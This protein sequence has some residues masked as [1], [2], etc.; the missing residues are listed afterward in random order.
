MSILRNHCHGHN[1]A[2]VCVCLPASVL[3]PQKEREKYHLKNLNT[4]TSAE[5]LALYG[6]L[7]RFQILGLIYTN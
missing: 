2:C 5:F 3:W 1:G 4:S 7:S 6:S